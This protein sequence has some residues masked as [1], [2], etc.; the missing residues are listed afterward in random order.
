MDTYKIAFG[1]TSEPKINY[2]KEVLKELNI[3]VVIEPVPVESGISEQPFTSAETKTGS[4]NRATSAFEKTKDSDFGIGIE[5][6]YERNDEGK[7]EMF[8]WTSIVNKNNRTSTRSHAFVLPEF[9]QEILKKGLN[10]GD[11]VR[12]YIS[13][14]SD[15]VNLIIGEDLRGRKPFIVNAVRS[16]LL[17]F[18]EK[19]D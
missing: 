5:V 16:C 18:L 12:E 10:L 4:L 14:N 3:D 8:C 11:Y 15:P 13:I 6:G 9:H 7:Y 1:G 19:K 2:L 17:L